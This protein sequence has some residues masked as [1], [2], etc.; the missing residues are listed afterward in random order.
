MSHR[1]DPIHVVN[2]LIVFVGG[3]LLIG[4]MGY[5]AYQIYKYSTRDRS[6]SNVILTD[7]NNSSLKSNKLGLG[8]FENIEGTP[9]LLGAIV[10]A[11]ESDR[12]YYTKGASSTTNYLILN[13][14]DKSAIRLVPK[15]NSLFIRAEKFGKNDR[16]GKLVQALGLWYVAVKADTNSDRRLT[17]ED[18]KIIAVSDVSGANYTEVIPNIDRLLNTFRISE[19]SIL[20]IYEASG[21]NFVSEIDLAQ[22]KVI[23]T[24][25]LPAID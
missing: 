18:R 17:E 22:K 14:K 16:D 13:V 3:I 15:N 7:S 21:K 23:E 11:Q 8:A 12:G 19:T 24:K 9:Y 10:L 1:P 5:V 4:L 25:E 6:I 2:K 20:T